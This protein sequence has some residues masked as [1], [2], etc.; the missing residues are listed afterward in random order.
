MKSILLPSFRRVYKT[1][2]EDVRQRA[3]QAYREWRNN[4]K[5]R[6]FKNVGSDRVSVRVDIN[7]RVL[8]ILRGDTVY[9]YWIGRHDE[10]DRRLS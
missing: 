4:P 7:Y 8:G 3:R 5:A 2:P 6:H 9:W 1:L 10:Y